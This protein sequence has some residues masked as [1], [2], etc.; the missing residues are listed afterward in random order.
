MRISKKSIL[1]A[2][3]GA[4]ALLF[5]TSCKKDKVVT[6]FDLNITLDESSFEQGVPSP[7]KY[8]V[9][10][11]NTNTGVVTNIESVGKNVS[12]K[13]L[14]GGVYDITATAQQSIYNYIATAK[15][16]TI[17]SGEAIKN[18]EVK[19]TRASTLIFKELYYI[20]SKSGKVYLKDNFFEIYNNGNADVYLDGLAI[21]TTSNYSAATVN[22]ANDKGN[23]VDLE[24]KDTG[25]KADDYLV[26]NGSNSVAWQ[27]PGDGTQYLLKPGESIIIASQAID[28]TKAC[29]KSI[30]LSA[31]EFETVADKYIT[32][33]QVDN[34]KSINL[35][36][37]NPLGQ[38]L[39]NWYM[40]SA[41]SAGFVLF[42]L[43]EAPD[44]LPSVTNVLAPNSKYKAI[45]R[46]KILDAVNWV[47]N[48]TEKPFLPADLDAGKIYCSGGTGVGKS[49]M[50]K[51]KESAENGRKIYKDSNN[52]SEDF[53]VSEKP[54][55]RRGDAAVPSWSQASAK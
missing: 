51:I 31:A 22:F 9:S 18:L 6:S 15:D 48:D 1:F 20:G 11:T 13:S 38:N 44:A 24:G 43:D 21:A 8:S 45:K 28:H 50:R 41:M 16:V 47:K 17:N 42:I 7:A 53:E 52:T 12:V 32:H 35:T 39:I 27:I 2:T 33:G 23:L 25:L 55:I 30:D 29:D 54:V 46:S 4:L 49:I 37:V 10:F 34:E 19:V 36:L 26:I 3:L 40:P 14:V 5:A